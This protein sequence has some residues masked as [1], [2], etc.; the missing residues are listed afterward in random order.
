MLSAQVALEAQGIDVL[1]T[2]G[3]L[4]PGPA[5]ISV[6]HDED[7]DEAK[8]IVATLQD[9]PRTSW[10]IEDDDFG[11]PERR[12]LH[13]KLVARIH[14]TGLMTAVGALMAGAAIIQFLQFLRGEP[15]R[16]W[17]PGGMG[18]AVSLFAAGLLISAY[19]W[20]LRYQRRL[21]LLKEFPKSPDADP[22]SRR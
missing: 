2:D 4:M 18:T 12:A 13:D 16:S 15:L 7:Y 10:L 21:R 5:R 8:A 9:T 14:R 17:I 22:P 1:V 11:S 20:R 3:M 19:G 6:V